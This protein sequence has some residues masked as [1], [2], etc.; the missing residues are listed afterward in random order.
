MYESSSKH[1]KWAYAN[2]EEPR[3]PS[4][5]LSKIGSF[6]DEEILGGIYHQFLWSKELWSKVPHQPGFQVRKQRFSGGER[7]GA[8][9]AK[10]GGCWGHLEAQD[11][12]LSIGK[13]PQR[14]PN[15]PSAY[16]C[17]VSKI[18]HYITIYLFLGQLVTFFWLTEICVPVEMVVRLPS[19]TRS[20]PKP[21]Q[22]CRP[23][24]GVVGNGMKANTEDLM[25]TR[26]TISTWA[27]LKME[28]TPQLWPFPPSKM[29]VFAVAI[30]GYYPWA[31]DLAMGATSEAKQDN[32]RE[33]ES[34]VAA[35]QK[36]LGGMQHW[37]TFWCFRWCF[38]DV[39]PRID[40]PRTRIW[41]FASQ[42]SC[43][44]EMVPP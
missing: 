38:D 14:W 44:A 10:G 11:A 41:G 26:P 19:W 4:H 22:S 33:V 18:I 27:Y 6:Q 21:M 30:G 3:N 25:E 39:Q 35:L 40:K 13:L 37:V 16:E 9:E 36:L 7:G 17:V 2:V 15:W 1:Q 5:S 24:G 23:M 34:Q 12:T 43:A 31:M 42:W 29:M 32:L 20:W 8:K 28:N